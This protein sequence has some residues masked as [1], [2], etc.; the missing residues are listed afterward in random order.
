M[1][2]RSREAREIAAWERMHGLTIL[3]EAGRNVTPEQRY[4]FQERTED[5]TTDSDP[6][7]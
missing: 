4:F 7:D 6:G 1:T 5:P 2:V 3:T